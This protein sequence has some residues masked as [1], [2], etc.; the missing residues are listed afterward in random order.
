MTLLRT[1][2]ALHPPGKGGVWTTGEVARGLGCCPRTVS[3]ACDRGLLPYYRVG[4]WHRRILEA[5]LVS[6]VAGQGMRWSDFLERAGRA[7]P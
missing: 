2:R 7:E 6:Y 3:E 1:R 4:R 5:D